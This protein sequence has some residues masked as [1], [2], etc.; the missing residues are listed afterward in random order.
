[1][2][3]YLAGLIEGD[4]SIIT[5]KN[6]RSPS[7]S[8]N[9][10]NIEIVFSIKD[11]YLALFIQIIIGGY[12]QYRGNACILYIKQKDQL[13]RLILLINGNMRTPKIEALHQLIIWFNKKHNL[14]IPLLGLDHSLLIENSWLAGYLDADG[15]FYFNWAL[16]DKK[17]VINLQYYLRI[18]QRQNYHTPT[19]LSKVG[20][21][22]FYILNKIANYLGV[23]LRSVTRQRKTGYLEKAF[24]VRSGSYIA[25]Y[26][27]T[28][29]LLKYPL[30][31]Y[32]YLGIDVFTQLLQLS[33]NKNYK[34]KN[35]NTLLSELKLNMT[36]ENWTVINK[37]EH[38]K[39]ISLYFPIYRD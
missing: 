37:T 11:L 29:Y 31:S 20:S 23:S 13:Y 3:S 12:I 24:E 32:K 25:N 38:Y 7:G 14:S 17:I 19:L 34:G 18:S 39:H 16:N 6:E 26:I 8:L 15:G 30:F 1:M 9:R 35:G 28:S 22:Y 27:I 36:S 2:G 21:S 10:G 4:G 5:P 33:K